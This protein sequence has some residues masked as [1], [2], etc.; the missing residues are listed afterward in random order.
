MLRKVHNCFWQALWFRQSSQ[1]EGKNHTTTPEKRLNHI[2]SIS[3][4][5]FEEKK[6]GVS[7]FRKSKVIPISNQSQ[8]KGRKK[9]KGRIQRLKKEDIFKKI[10]QIN[11]NFIELVNDEGN[12]LNKLHKQRC[13][14][15]VGKI[16]KISVK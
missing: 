10:S 12:R 5:F 1:N 15:S 14:S 4:W 7:L 6:L 16:N 11:S 13:W 2:K 9:L 8:R 3:F